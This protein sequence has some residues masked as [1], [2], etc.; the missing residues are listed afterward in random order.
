MSTDY[1]N[2]IASASQSEVGFRVEFG[3]T[4]GVGTIGR[5]NSVGKVCTWISRMRRTIQ[6]YVIVSI[7][8]G[9]AASMSLVGKTLF[10]TISRYERCHSY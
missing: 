9:V 8:G 1:Q 5:G 2:L 3:V 4:V 7:V 10:P 6:N